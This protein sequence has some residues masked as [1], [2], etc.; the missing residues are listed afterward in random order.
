MG[1]KILVTGGAKIAFLTGKEAKIPSFIDNMYLV[2]R[3]V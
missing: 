3:I 1:K 2:V